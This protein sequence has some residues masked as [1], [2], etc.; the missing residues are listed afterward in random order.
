[1]RFACFDRWNDPKP[2][3]AGVTEA[4]WTSGVDGTRT[5]ELTCVSETTVGKGDRIVFT[6][7][8]GNLQETVVVSP[9]HRREDA[10]IVTSPVCKGSV[11]ELDDTFVEDK[12]NRSATASEC[13]RKALENTRWSVGTVDDDGTFVDLSFYHIST[14]QAV[15]DIADKFGLEVT[16]GYLMD[17]QHLRIT[18]R[19]VNLVK[20]Q[21]D[22]TGEGLRRFE[23]GHD[24]KGITRTVD[25]TG[26]KTRLYGYGKR[27]ATTDENGEQ[28]S[29]YGRRIDFADIN[30]G[31]PYVEDP[32][33]TK[34]WGIPG[35]VVESQGKNLVKGGGFEL[36]YG[37]GWLFSPTPAFLDA[38]IKADGDVK[39]HEGKKMLRMGTDPDTSASKAIT[40]YCSVKGNTDYELSL[41]TYGPAGSSFGVT[42]TQNVNV[43]PTSDITLAGPANNGGRIRTKRRFTTH[44]AVSP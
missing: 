8:R 21:G 17:P 41:W 42:I 12:R 3:L 44:A 32:T 20:A 39:P 28:T 23:Y 30:N 2:D 26:V 38:I 19:A 4:K 25:A 35:P 15:E 11:S 7:P 1:M 37:D 10:L 34:L 31:K 43:Y 13:L 14:L 5:L 36:T 16:A 6:D 9:E 27:L 18:D 40:E 24:L 33:D 29:G 22:Q